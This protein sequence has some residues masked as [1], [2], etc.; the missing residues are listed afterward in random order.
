MTPENFCFWLQG[1]FEIDGTEEGLNKTQ[2]EVIREHLQLV[3][4]KVTTQKP[5]SQIE[6]LYR[7]GMQPGIMH[8]GVYTIKSQDPSEYTTTCHS[9]APSHDAVYQNPCPSC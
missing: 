8:Q 9:A 6:E 7:K 2:A 4:N 1:Y 5:N 3:F